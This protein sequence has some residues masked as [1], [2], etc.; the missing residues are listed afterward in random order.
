MFLNRLCLGT[1]FSL[2]CLASRAAPSRW[3]LVYKSVLPD[4][5]WNLA[6][7]KKFRREEIDA[8][9]EDVSQLGHA[10]ISKL[11]KELGQVTP[12]A[13]TLIR[14]EQLVQN[15]GEVQGMIKSL[16][17]E[18]ND[19]TMLEVAQEEA[20]ELR[21]KLNEEEEALM[22]GILPVDEDD[23][24]NAVLEIRAGTG[25]EEAALFVMDLFHMYEA[26]AKKMGWKFRVIDVAEA[27]AGGYKDA[28]ATVSGEAVYS[29]L[30]FEV[31]THRVQRVPATETQGRVH[32][33]ASTVA[34]LPE[35]QQ[36]DIGEINPSDLRIDTY[37]SQGAGGQHVNT[38]ESA[39]RITHIPTGIVTS[40]Q[41][42]RSQGSNKLTAMKHLYTKLYDLKKQQLHEQRTDLRNSM[43]G[44]GERNERIRTYNYNQARITDHRVNLSK[45]GMEAMMEGEFLEEFIEALKIHNRIELLKGVQS[46]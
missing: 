8:L 41:E 43:V 38:T 21:A 37:R 26:F 30:K 17:K 12:V 35:A 28:S 1:S 15:L 16:E 33:S 7:E 10:E 31:G 23:D 34:V 20:K 40:C 5:I 19:R 42:E 9:F 3:G 24:R 14:I 32:T 36:V 25:G 4:S 2:R 27:E 45:Y 6:L 13:D 46:L 44:R 39:V 29:M 11:S 18:N 22:E